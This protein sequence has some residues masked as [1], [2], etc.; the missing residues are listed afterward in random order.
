M[1]QA[2]HSGDAILCTKLASCHPE[3]RAS[4]CG[5][6]IG[7][8][9]TFKILVLGP[10]ELHVDGRSDP[11]GSAKGRLVLAA[12]AIDAGR[13]VTLDTL[14][15]RVWDDNPPGKPRASLHAYAARIRRTLRI[16][17]GQ[18]YLAQQAHAYTLNVHPEKVDAHRFQRLVTLARSL[19]DS[20]EDVQA[21]NLLRQADELWRGDPLSG[22]PGLW[23][24]SVRTNLADK[25]LAATLTRIDIELRMGHFAE[26][27]PD[28]TTLLE[29]HPTDEHIASKLVIANYAYGRQADALRTYDAVRRRLREELGA[30]PGQSLSRL[31]GLILNQAPVTDLLGRR[32]PAKGVPNTLPSHGDLIGRQREM[33]I[34]QKP[35]ADGAVIALQTITGMAGVGKSLLALHLARRL[36]PLFPDG[37]VHLD[38]G[39]HSAR[40]QPLSPQAALSTLLRIF[41]V[42]ASAIPDDPGE[43]SALWRTL[44]GNRRAVVILDDAVDAEQLR[45]LLPGASP[46]LI[47]ITSR[48]RLTGLPGVRLLFLDVLPAEDAVALFRRLVGEERTEDQTEVSEI[49]RLCGHLPLAIELAAGRMASRPSWT[50][51]HLIQKLS[52]EPGRIGEIRDGYREIARAFAMSYYTLT[53]DQQAAFRLLSLHLG[54]DFGPHAAAALMGH[55]MDSAE[56]ILDALLDAHLLQEPAPD[57]YRFHDLVGE[58]ARTLTATEDLAEDRNPA[59]RRVIDFY[60]QASRAAA[61]LTHPR[62]LQLDLPHD[63]LPSQLPIW[64]DAQAAKQW[65]TQERMGLI[66]AESHARAH[67]RPWQAALLAHALGGFLDDDGYWGVA[68]QMHG[69]AA[70]YWRETGNR[71]AEVYALVD[72]G[73]ALSH[74]GHYE[75]ALA[76]TQR[77]LDVASALGDAMAKAEAVHLLGLLSW[78]RG[79][80]E[81]AL[82]FQ[83][84]ALAL[85]RHSGDAWL[86]ARSHNNLGI[87]HLF[88]GNYPESEKSFRAALA[89]F[90][91]AGDTRRESH[92]LNNL[93]DL[94]I[95]TGDRDSARRILGESLELIATAGMPSAHAI[96]QVNLANTMDTADETNAALELYGEALLTF[97]RLGDRRNASITLY[98]MGVAYHTADRTVE[99]AAHHRRA[100]D[101]ARSIG[102]AHEEAQA[103][104]GLGTAEHRLG[105]LGSAAEHLEAAF[106]LA[107]RIGATKEA[108]QAMDELKNL[109]AGTSAVKCVLA[110]SPAARPPEPPT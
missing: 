25:R 104:R 97:Q 47:I 74:S 32:A 14:I 28:L 15:Q 11:L 79:R 110:A 55:Q 40:R 107:S 16:G 63:S 22:L 69:P 9:V 46:S 70:D 101:L 66:A 4:E 3:Y 108:A 10:V 41:G 60:V 59:I 2:D 75:Q 58:Y 54:P 35:P 43:L 27:I 18:D 33:R 65:L 77:A 48:R 68:R 109:R 83:N 21:L 71:L 12:L 36:A 94:R 1:S 34:L 73:D 100:L 23:A 31:H 86:I 19:S 7:A 42:S 45:P 90:R 53:E 8:L 87:T 17:S 24:E 81:E 82:S 38:L 30:S 51:S 105:E 88:L 6:A 103:Q 62:R 102:A 92:V 106:A 50:M 57:R 95:E 13:P 37:L 49:V 89:G 80:L 78:N 93:A 72:L 26:L 52:R 29:Q 20:G 56:R 67:G 39:A 61:Q 98:R 84:A 64:S 99:A 44:L 5:P 85:R 76:S 96:A 91:E